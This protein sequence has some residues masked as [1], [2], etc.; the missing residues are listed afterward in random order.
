M[1]LCFVILTKGRNDF[2]DYTRDLL[3]LLEMTCPVFGAVDG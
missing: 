3:L 1:S 2:S